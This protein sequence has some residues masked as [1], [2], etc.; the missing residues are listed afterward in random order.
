MSDPLLPPSSEWW[1]SNIRRSRGL[2]EVFNHRP[3]NLDGATCH[4]IRFDPFPT[5]SFLT[6]VLTDFPENPPE[7]W[8]SKKADSIE[9]IIQMTDCHS[10]HGGGMV[11]PCAIDIASTPDRQ[12]NIILEAKGFNLGFFARFGLLSSIRAIKH[13]SNVSFG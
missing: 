10:I 9:L 1:A 3:A 8:R 12:F 13:E 11:K 4:L 5:T 2:F 6:I 7:R